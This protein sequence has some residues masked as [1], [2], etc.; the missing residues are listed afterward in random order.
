MLLD[1]KL[2]QI[3]PAVLSSPPPP[4]APT[5]GSAVSPTA[6]IPTPTT[7]PFPFVSDSTADLSTLLA[8]FDEH[9]KQEG[10]GRKLKL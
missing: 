6:P 2:I 8:L 5:P 1:H 4:S 7:T 3:L 10:L 9:I